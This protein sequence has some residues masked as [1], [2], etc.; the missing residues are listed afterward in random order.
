MAAAV[1]TAGVVEVGVGV[2]V[3]VVEVEAGA[4]VVEAG[5]GAGA[6]A[7]TAG[8]AEVGVAVPMAEAGAEVRLAEVGVAVPTAE[9]GA[10]SPIVEAWAGTR[11]QEGWVREPSTAPPGRLATG[12]A[13]APWEAFIRAWLPIIPCT[14]ISPAMTASGVNLTAASIIGGLP[15]SAVSD[16]AG[17][18]GVGRYPWWD[19][20]ASMPWWYYGDYGYPAD[21]YTAAY[22][23]PAVV[24]GYA[25]NTPI[26]T[27][28]THRSGRRPRTII[29]ARA[30]ETFREGSYASA[31]RLA[32]HAAMDNP[33]DPNV[34]LLLSLSMFALGNYQG[35]AAE[36]HAV[37]A[38]GAKVDWASLIGFYNNN[39]GTYTSQLRALEAYVTKN[40]SLTAARFLVGFHY[41]AEGHKDA[42]QTELLPVVNAVP[43]DRITADLLTQAGGHVPESVARQLKEKPGH[44]PE[45]T[46]GPKAAP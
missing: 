11:L 15:G 12:A 46:P 45:Q 21:S 26:E 41:L 33:R 34:H 35:A 44:A 20:Y 14:V 3:G 25:D 37:A 31:L 40:P 13:P 10:A 2:G 4:G 39:V 8:G 7:I 27:A 38:M 19:D 28:P 29:Y 5:A 6:E 17:L 1:A 18:A 32:G 42:A 43:Q 23:G 9:A 36:A 16:S 30:L 22:A 24:T